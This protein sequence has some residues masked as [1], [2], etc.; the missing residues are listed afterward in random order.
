MRFELVVSMAGRSSAPA[1]A[2]V[3][4]QGVS[5]APAFV[6]AVAGVDSA[7]VSWT[8]P[9]SD[10]NSPIQHSTVKASPGGITVQVTGNGTQALVTGLSAGTTYVFTVVA[11]NAFGD[12]PP[13]APSN[14]VTVF[15]NPGPPTGV[16]A[17]R[18]NQQVALAWTAPSDTG[19]I[20][21]SGYRITGSP[22]PATPIQV[23]ASPTAAIVPGLAN[24]VSYVFTVVA[25]GALSA[26]APSN[27]VTPATLPGAA[28]GVT[29]APGNSSATVALTAPASDGGDPIFSYTVV[30]SPGG[31]TVV[32]GARRSALP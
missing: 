31:V 8:A 16:I 4:T 21:L 30:A 6:G 32:V 17:T 13:S 7:T 29:A 2:D 5:T 11:T 27:A 15:T 3:A 10:G 18:G 24:G 14:A 28:S 9:A 22:A 26:G 25:D 19:G 1:T 12:S 23:P 20:P